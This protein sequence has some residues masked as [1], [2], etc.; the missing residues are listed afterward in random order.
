MLAIPVVPL[1][2][3]PLCQAGQEAFNEGI[4]LVGIFRVLRINVVHERNA[5]IFGS[6]SV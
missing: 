6:G 4:Y 1:A 2:F 3:S 5:R